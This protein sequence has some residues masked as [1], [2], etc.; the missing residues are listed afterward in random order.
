MN[1]EAQELLRIR[2]YMDMIIA[3]STGQPYDKV[4]YDLSRNKVRIVATPSARH[5]TP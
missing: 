4:A 5:E 2:D 1:R 3:S